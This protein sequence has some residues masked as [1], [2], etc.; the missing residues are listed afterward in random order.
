MLEE[1]ALV[2]DVFD[3]AAY[4]NPAYADMC[5]AQ[6]KAPL[7][8]EALVRDLCNGAWSQHCASRTG[9]HRLAGEIL[10]KLKTANRLY[11]CAACDP[12]DVATDA[13]WC[14]ESLASAGMRPL[15]GVIAAHATKASKMFTN[16]GRIASIEKLAGSSWWKN[17]CSQTSVRNTDAYLNLLSRVL[18]QANS[19]MFIDP[20]LDPSQ[21]NY[22]EFKDLVAPLQHRH[23]KPRVEIHRS[24]CRGDGK[25]RTFPTQV[26]WSQAFS[27]LGDSLRQVGVSAEVFF[28]DDFHDRFLITDIVGL[29]VPA[30]FD[31]TTKM[32]E[33]TTWSRLSPH[34][35]EYWQR[36]FDPA[37]RAK[38][39]KWRF[40]IGADVAF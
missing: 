6:L 39:F 22:R 38:D 13:D 1:Y 30:G 14:R 40:Q 28:W 9:L 32:D 21:N 17:P 24:L 26:E 31:T 4:S 18:P 11:Q 3:A 23:I 2:P 36:Q 12:G 16:D 33:L 37:V 35:R 15:T 7:L 5:L 19:M 34:D 27:G 29:S 20:N 8:H 10:R 25:A